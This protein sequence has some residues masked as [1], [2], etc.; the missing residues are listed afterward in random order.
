MRTSP[1][2]MST[3]MPTIMRAPNPLSVLGSFSSS[4]RPF[5][6]VD[7]LPPHMVVYVACAQ[8]GDD[9]AAAVLPADADRDLAYELDELG[10]HAEV[11]RVEQARQVLAGDHD[12]VQ[13]VAGACMS[14]RHGALG[15]RDD[16]DRRLSGQHLIAE[17]VSLRRDGS[18]RFCRTKSHRGLAHPMRPA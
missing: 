2:T 15:L 5:I 13:G 7:F 9:P 14:E 10:L 3:R 6:S 8:V 12:D 17:E 1:M 16:L 11:L 4:L 18:V